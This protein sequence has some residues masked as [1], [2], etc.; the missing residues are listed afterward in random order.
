MSVS[1]DVQKCVTAT[2]DHDSLAGLECLGDAKLFSFNH[3]GGEGPQ[4]LYIG[5]SN[6]QQYAPRILRLL[7]KE[8]AKSE[9]ALFF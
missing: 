2:R 1:G 8:H 7:T 4:T 6:A 5:D 3:A 9:R